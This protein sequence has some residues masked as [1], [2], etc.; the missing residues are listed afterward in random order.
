MSASRRHSDKLKSAYKFDGNAVKVKTETVGLRPLK[1][2]FVGLL[3]ILQLAIIICLNVWF[4]MAFEIYL[5]ISVIFSLMT[6]IYCLSSSKNGLSKAVWVMIL[7][8]GASFGFIVYWLSDERIFFYRPKKRYR[9]IFDRT[10]KFCPEY[11]PVNSSVCVQNDCDYLYTAGKFAAYTATQI[12]YFPSGTQLFDDVLERLKGAEKFV[13]IE[14]FIISDGRL[15]DKIVGI[16]SK[17]AACGVDVRIIYDDMG[18]HSVL[19]RKMKMKIRRA[20]IKLTAYNRLV[21]FFNVALN[22][23]DHR[24]MIVVDGKT[25]YS[26]GSNLADEYVNEKRMH[27]YWKDTGVR[28]DGEAVDGMSLIFLRQWEYLSGI[29]EDYTPFFGNYE[30][31]PNSSVVAPYADGLDFEK[32]VGKNVYENIISGAKE[33]LWIM[34]PY[35]IPDEIITGLLKNKA[36]SNVD[37]RIILPEVPDKAFAYAVTRN[38]AEKLIGCGVKIYC[39]KHSFVHSKLILTENCA[40]IGSI[41]MDLRSFFQQFECAVYTDDAGVMQDIEKDFED[42]FGKSEIIDEDNGRRSKL[43]NRALAGVLQIFAPLM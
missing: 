11:R 43:R 41:N 42:T 24:K 10:D 23:R 38:N 30:K 16:L 20:G 13:F 1:T 37:V 28:I 40:V 15:L 14:Y 9:A 39:M 29:K 34:T 22:Y 3:I 17:K 4:G 7:L 18:S 25:A 27:G 36:A 19:S 2:I 6:C 26:G 5:L 32:N 21:P 33:R 12:K 35:F 8:L 31:F